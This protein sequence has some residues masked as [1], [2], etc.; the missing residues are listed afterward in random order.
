VTGKAQE[1]I[2]WVVGALV[3]LV[4]VV[5]GALAFRQR[6]PTGAVVIGESEAKQHELAMEREVEV[7]G[8]AVE[9]VEEARAE[10]DKVARVP[11]VDARSEALSELGNRRRRGDSSR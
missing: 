7:I 2:L 3:G 8:E 9:E 4:T 5:L 1:W 11:G 6:R 10:T